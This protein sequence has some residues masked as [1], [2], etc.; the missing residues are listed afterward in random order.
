M[1]FRDCWQGTVWVE[2]RMSTSR[3][4]ILGRLTDIPS[5]RSVID[6]QSTFADGDLW[7]VFEG[8]LNALGGRLIDAQGLEGML[9]K[10]CFIEGAASGLL[11]SF[12]VKFT[13][14]GE[15]IWDVDVG[16]TV[17]DLAIAEMGSLVVSAGPEKRRMSS[18]VP[19][20]N[21]M[22]VNRS[23]IV[24]TLA[25]AIPKISDRSSAIITGPS[26][27]ADIEGILVRGVH[28]PGELL[29]YVYD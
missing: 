24:G 12:G 26:R 23:A 13:N 22:L 10:T 25:E 14:S 2:L 6:V 3:E 20:T 29:V 11:Q 5:E 17:A 7:T 21:V 16:I 1:A 19:P 15:D 28:G 18:L 9:T 4:K 27:T 8:H